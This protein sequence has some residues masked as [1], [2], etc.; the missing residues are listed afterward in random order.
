MERKGGEAGLLGD[1]IE[2]TIAIVTMQ[3][4]RL[5]IARAG[6]QRVDLR[7]DVAVGDEKIE[8]GVIVHIKEPSTPAN[9]RIAGL[10]DA[11][12]PAHVV[13]SL[14]AHIAIERVGLLLKMGNEEAQAAA[15]VIIAPVPS[16]VAELHPFAAKSHAGKHA[17][18]RESAIVIVVVEVVGNG[19][20]G[21]Q[22][23]RPAIVVVIDPHDAEAVVADLIMDAGFDGNF[24]KGAVATIVIQKIALAFESPGAALH[25]NA[26]EAAKLIAAELRQIAHVQ[27]GIARDVKI[28]E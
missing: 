17:H 19:I 11:G 22:E 7:V 8:P 25:Q 13:E 15:V 27:M 2:S 4:Q 10:A 1:F 20:V 18:V 24:L 21:D 6:V 26:F 12:S 5:A 3:K 23:V 14:L 9:V 16:H 28:N